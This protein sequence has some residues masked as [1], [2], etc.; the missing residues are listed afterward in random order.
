[1]DLERKGRKRRVRA[2]GAG[3]L[4]AGMG[5]GQH[6][7]F[8]IFLR[9]AEGLLPIEQRGFGQRR[10]ASDFGQILHADLRAGQPLLIGMAV[11]QFGLEIMIGDGLAL[12]QIDQQHLAGLQTP[13]AGDV[14]FGNIKDAHFRASRTKPSLV[15][16]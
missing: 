15:S 2:H 1:M 12:L 10:G 7:E 5:H 14:L 4:L 11:G 3:C 9:I 13:F 8:Q 6:Q 16:R